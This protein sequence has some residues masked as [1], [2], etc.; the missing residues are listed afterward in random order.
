[1]ALSFEEANKALGQTYASPNVQNNVQPYLPNTQQVPQYDTSQAV[2]S[3]GGQGTG[4]FF[5]GDVSPLQLL[6]GMGL[7]GQ[8]KLSQAYSVLKPTPVTA[9][10]QK[11]KV[12]KAQASQMDNALNSMYKNWGNIPAVQRLPIPLIGHIAPERAKY[13]SA[14]QL[15][16]QMLILMVEDKRITDQN[17][18]FYLQM[19]PSLLDS[20]K[21]AKIKVQNI[22]SFVND[23]SNIEPPTSGGGTDINDLQLLLG[24]Q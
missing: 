5:G 13:E 9:A 10:Q 12:Q 6:L 22:K 20:Q 16:N 19:F 17:R 4:N 3:T 18:K 23:L 7:L 1:M 14:K 2:P 8:N 21:V 15:Y 24:G 11:L